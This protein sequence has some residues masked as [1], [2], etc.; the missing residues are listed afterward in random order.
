[1]LRSA[2]RARR[3][4]VAS[5]FAA[6]SFVGPLAPAAHAKA[7]K[8]QCDAV[9]ILTSVNP[10]ITKGA[11]QVKTELAR[12]KSAQA[13]IPA[14]IKGDA[15]KIQAFWEALVKWTAKY[16]DPVKAMADPRGL[17]DYSKLMEKVTTDVA[18]ALQHVSGW[19]MMQCI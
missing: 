10:D 14:E 3:I 7:T 5:V 18:P 9:Q 1:M 19:T 12:L 16:R 6:A 13:N 4:V 11:K 2:I 15:K 17:A 8:A